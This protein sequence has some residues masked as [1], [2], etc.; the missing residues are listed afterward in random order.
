MD[1]RKSVKVS[2]MNGDPVE[3]RCESI[4]M[5]RRHSRDLETEIV[6]VFG[7][8]RVKDS[9]EDVEKQLGWNEIAGNTEVGNA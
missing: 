6:T 2:L 7:S 5:L 8:I 3:I 1:L 9:M 4:G